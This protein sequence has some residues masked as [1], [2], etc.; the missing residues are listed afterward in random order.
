MSWGKQKEEGTIQRFKMD[1]SVVKL[2]FQQNEPL[3]C[4]WAKTPA[5]KKKAPSKIWLEKTNTIKPELTWLLG[6]NEV[7]YTIGFAAI[8]ALK[9]T[10]EKQFPLYLSEITVI[11][12]CTSHWSTLSE[13]TFQYLNLPYTLNNCRYGK[14]EVHRDY[15]DFSPLACWAESQNYVAKWFPQFEIEHVCVCVCV[16]VWTGGIRAIHSLAIL[17]YFCETRP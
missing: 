3:Q 11:S 14:R 8:K 2:L 4:I 17:P 13:G 1:K 9:A 5:Q 7:S 10:L 15:N 12:W 6:R 16:R